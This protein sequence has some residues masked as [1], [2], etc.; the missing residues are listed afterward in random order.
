MKR[1]AADQSVIDRAIALQ[2]EGKT[3]AE[4]IQAIALLV[5]MKN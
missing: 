5:M 1:V 2:D 4:I 3:D